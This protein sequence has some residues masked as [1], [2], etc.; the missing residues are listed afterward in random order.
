MPGGKLI[1]FEP[2]VQQMEAL[3]FF[4]GLLVLLGILV[5]P[6]S[7]RIGAPILLVVLLMGMLL[8]ED[9]PGGIQFSDFSM[10][11]AIG[12]LALAVILFAGGLET[13]VRKTRGARVPSIV[14]ATLG[15]LVTAIV[16]GLFAA[17]ILNVPIEVALLL[18]AVV[19][20]T[21][22]AATFLLI[23]QGGVAVSDRLRNTLILE[24]GLNDPVAIFLTVTLTALVDSGAVLSADSL[25]AKLPL[26]GVQVGVG[27]AVGIVG[28]WLSSV[29]LDRMSLPQGLHP[30]LAL[31]CGLIVYS[32]TALVGGSGFLAVYLC[33][34]VIASHTKRPIDRVLHFNEALQWLSQISLFLMLG[35]LVTPTGLMERAPQ[36]LMI[37]AALMFVAR[38]LAV[39][40]C[41]AFFGFRWKETLFLGWVGLRGAVPIFLAIFPVVTPG[42]VTVE[43]FNIVFVVVVASLLLQGTT[44]GLFA[45]LLGLS[46][47]PR[48]R[49]ASKQATD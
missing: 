39:A 43:F 25:L 33:G 32:G 5:V 21:D 36:A 34:L 40:L 17:P 12:S 16:V 31:V 14:L 44:I 20:S 35:L 15:V 27:I 1:N 7:Q 22:A 3:I 9:G 6:L 48:P 18:G 30:P 47:G 10:A 38:P 41:V 29:L 23:Q 19:A 49:S 37:A 46:G 45:R 24:S 26:L 28:G 8:G 2:L 4:I 11:Y 13:D 42:P